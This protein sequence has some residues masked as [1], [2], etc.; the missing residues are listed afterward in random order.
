MVYDPCNTNEI[1]DI[2][3]IVEIREE[4]IEWKDEESK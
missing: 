4:S 3:K 2:V 1:A